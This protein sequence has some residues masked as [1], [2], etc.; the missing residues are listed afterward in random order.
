MPINNIKNISEVMYMKINELG[1]KNTEEVRQT[2][3][4]RREVVGTRE[5]G[6]VQ[7]QNRVQTRARVRE[8]VRFQARN[9]V[10]N[11]VNKAV[12]MPEIREE[13]VAQ[14][15]QQVQTG[16]YN[17]SNREIARAMIGNLLNEIA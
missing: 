9:M 17:V 3:Q 10:E 11:A 7:V 1:G 8:V 5:T 6:E 16:T 13:K 4:N 15:K 2:R 12:N 14:I